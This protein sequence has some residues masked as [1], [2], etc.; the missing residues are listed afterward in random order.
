MKVRRPCDMMPQTGNLELWLNAG[1]C[2]T[3]VGTCQADARKRRSAGV[4]LRDAQD[5]DEHRDAA[6]Y[7]GQGG[8]H[9]GGARAP[10]VQ[11]QLLWRAAARDRL[12]VLE[13]RALFL[14]EPRY[15]GL[16]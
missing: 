7:G 10:Q 1:C 11:Q 16:S 2:P 6:H 9:C 12:W 13:V 3:Q 4:R 14:T 8:P 5:G 15:Y